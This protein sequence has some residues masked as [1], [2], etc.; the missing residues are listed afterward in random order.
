MATANAE[1]LA[2][3]KLCKSRQRV[4]VLASFPDANRLSQW[5]CTQAALV[6]RLCPRQVHTLHFRSNG[7]IMSCTIFRVFFMLTDFIDPE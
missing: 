4:P 3:E 1:V 6:F 2:V 5:N 7:G